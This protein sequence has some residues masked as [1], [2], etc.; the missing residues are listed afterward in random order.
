M[1]EPEPQIRFIP[2]LEQWERR[3][4][5]PYDFNL[6]EKLREKLDEILNEAEK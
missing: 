4:K 3:K 5:L 1:A 6:S 2:T